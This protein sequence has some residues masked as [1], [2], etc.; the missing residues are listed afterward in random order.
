MSP[1]TQ[2]GTCSPPYRPVSS[3][4][5]S[6]LPWER[7]NADSSPGCAAQS[8]IMDNRGHFHAFSEKTNFFQNFI[9]P[10]LVHRAIL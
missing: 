3:R 6:V 2:G 5:G 4:Q 8:P 10:Y 7:L 1:H 9:L